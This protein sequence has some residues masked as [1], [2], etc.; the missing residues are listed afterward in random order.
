MSVAAPQQ[1]GGRT[2]YVPNAG[3]SQEVSNHHFAEP[4]RKRYR[5]G[6]RQRGLKGRRQWFKGSFFGAG[7]TTSM[8]G[9][10]FD[11]SLQAAGLKAPN[12]LKRLLRLR[13]YAR[14]TDS[15]GQAVVLW[16]V[17]LSRGHASTSPGMFVN[18]NA[19]DI[20]KW[21]YSPDLSNQ[22]LNDE[23]Y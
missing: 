2:M 17:A 7:S 18:Q 13:G 11:A 19:G 20:T 14:W 23:Y 9:T 3:S 21:T 15:Q 5:R 6:H 1:N 10:N 8:Q 12:S 16:R 4:R 22:A